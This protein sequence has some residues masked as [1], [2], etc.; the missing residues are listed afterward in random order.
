MA[1]QHSKKTTTMKWDLRS[2]PNLAQIQQ[3]VCSWSVP[4]MG[5]FGQRVPNCYFLKSNTVLFCKITQVTILTANR[6]AMKNVHSTKLAYQGEKSTF[7]SSTATG[8][9]M[10][11]IQ[12]QK[13]FN[14]FLA[15]HS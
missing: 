7:S 10:A 3:K 4:N 5:A 14:S 11:L 6:K 1:Q 8:A 2:A 12:T 15:T 9:I 13:A